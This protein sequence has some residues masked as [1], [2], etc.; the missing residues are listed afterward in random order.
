MRLQCTAQ[1][2]LHSWLPCLPA[3]QPIV[4]AW[5]GLVALSEI[6]TKNEFL[7]ELSCKV[8]VSPSC[9]STALLEYKKLANCTKYCYTP[10]Q[11]FHWWNKRKE[12]KLI[13]QQALGWQ[14]F[15]LAMIA[16]MGR[17]HVK[18][19]FSFQIL[20]NYELYEASSTGAATVSIMRASDPLCGRFLL[21]KLNWCFWHN[22]NITT[23]FS[24]FFLSI[25][26]H[27]GI[28]VH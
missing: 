3:R 18:I 1:H 26:V 6:I 13:V 27:E 9:S 8:K 24:I 21:T 20:Y 22:I 7:K 11:L 4:L 16:M 28:Y 25:Y 12:K 5:A 15:H 23:L 10:W 2:S 14:L 17:K 19:L